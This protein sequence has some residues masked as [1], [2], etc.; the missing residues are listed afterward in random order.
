MIQATQEVCTVML[1]GSLGYVG[2][3]TAG[4]ETPRASIQNESVAGYLGFPAGLFQFS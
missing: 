2:G 4:L 1:D 3:P